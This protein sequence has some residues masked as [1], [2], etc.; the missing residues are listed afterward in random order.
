MNVIAVLKEEQQEL[1]E[2]LHRI[3][4]ALRILNHVTAHRRVRRAVHV[5]HAHSL[6][7][8]RKIGQGVKAAHRRK[9]N[10]R[11]D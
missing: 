10:K 8:R 3:S 4:K 11:E 2:Q 6:T 1:R 5:R 7:V 9:N